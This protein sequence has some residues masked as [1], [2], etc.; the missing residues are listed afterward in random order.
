MGLAAEGRG[1]FTHSTTVVDAC[2]GA[3]LR[4]PGVGE[5][6]PARVELPIRQRHIPRMGQRLSHALDKFS[7]GLPPNRT[8]EIGT[9]NSVFR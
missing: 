7:S 5:T 8:R 6:A 1:L 9:T 4:G 2:W 3:G